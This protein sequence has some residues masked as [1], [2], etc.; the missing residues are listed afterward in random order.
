MKKSLL[1]A[2]ILFV[3]VAFGTYFLIAPSSQS[4]RIRECSLQCSAE[5]CIINRKVA[6]K[7]VELCAGTYETLTMQIHG[8]CYAILRGKKKEIQEKIPADQDQENN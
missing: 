8:R 4:Q 2:S 3:V 7:C 6:E 1:W 5:K